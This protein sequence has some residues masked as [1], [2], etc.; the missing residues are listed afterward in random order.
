MAN[1][2]AT[3]ARGEVGNTPF[4]YLDNKAVF[5]TLV[6]PIIIIFVYW[7]IKN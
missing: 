2:V 3:V 4:K 7:L 5:P 1:S 6:S